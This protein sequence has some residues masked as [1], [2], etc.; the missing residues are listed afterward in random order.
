LDEFSSVEF[1]TVSFDMCNLLDGSI[2]R[3]NDNIKNTEFVRISGNI[4][5]IVEDQCF[6]ILKC[7]N[8]ENVNDLE[9]NKT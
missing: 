3:L 9:Q 1:S 2:I 6:L 4:M 8:C 7:L 5:N